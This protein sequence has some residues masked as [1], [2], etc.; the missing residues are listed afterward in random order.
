MSATPASLGPITDFVRGGALEASLPEE[1][2]GELDLMI[3]ELLMNVCSHA[4]PP[5][6]QGD[7][8]VAYSIPAPGELSVEVADRGVHFDPLRAAPPDLSL[9]LE[10]RPI[11]GLGL[12]LVKT[13]AKS[14]AY[15]RDQGWNRLTFGI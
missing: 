3:E 14:I 9:N 11:G 1:R 12:H 4:Y 8:T 2:I 10:D 13:L 6:A 5:G 15:R 7:V